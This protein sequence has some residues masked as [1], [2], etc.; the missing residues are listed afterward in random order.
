MI[1]QLTAAYHDRKAVVVLGGLSLL[2]FVVFIYSLTIGAVSLS[3]SQA[4]TII[5]R[6]LGISLADVSTIQENVF[7]TIRL[8]RLIQTIIIGGALGVSGAALQGL[9]RNPLVE[10]G[11]VGVSNGA[12]MAAALFIVFGAQ[13]SARFFPWLGQLLLPIVAFSGGLISTL[14]V[15]R[16]SRLYGKTNVSMLILS[17][18]AIIAMSQAFIGLAVFYANENQA[19]AYSFW[20]LGDLG[21]AT[22]SKILI[23]F[24]LILV[25]SAVI[26]R[27]SKALNTMAAGESEAFYMG[28]N[29]ERMKMIAIVCAAMAVG[30]AVSLAGVIAFVGL[31]IPHMIRL[32]FGADH[33]LVLPASL[34]GGATLLIVSDIIAR[35]IVSPAELPIGIVTAMIGTPFFIYLLRTA[36]Q[37]HQV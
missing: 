3:A 34:L 35:T 36:K 19:R 2:L 25:P 33:R 37:S 16:L 1:T 31:V 6:P 5:F 24:P 20:T 32:S 10:P 21:G 4:L 30:T 7:L 15:Y 18:V 13:W 17:G 9:F 27:Y 8:P 29:V 22:W 26:I 12:A 11:L 28:V 23:T 14:V